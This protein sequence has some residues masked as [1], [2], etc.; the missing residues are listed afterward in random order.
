[1]LSLVIIEAIDNFV[2]QKLDIKS[3]QKDL[4]LFMRSCILIIVEVTTIGL[5]QSSVLMVADIVISALR[6]SFLVSFRCAI[7]ALFS[8][9]PVAPLYTAGA[10]AQSVGTLISGPVL[11]ATFS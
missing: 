1:M 6:S 2:Q 8:Q 9:T 10:I 5:A 7:V 11:A 4:L 3:A